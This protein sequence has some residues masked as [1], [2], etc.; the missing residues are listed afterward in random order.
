MNEHKLCRKDLTEFA[1]HLQREERS[2]GTIAKYER[3]V[4]AFALWLGTG[5]WTGR[6]SVP[7]RRSFSPAAVRQPR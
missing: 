4:N 1:Q 5:R 3:D 7:G 6:R 2:P